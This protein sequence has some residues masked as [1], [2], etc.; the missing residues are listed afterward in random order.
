MPCLH[1]P[2]PL[3]VSCSY[4]KQCFKSKE[5]AYQ[6]LHL[7]T[8]SLDTDLLLCARVGDAK[9]DKARVLTPV[10]FSIWGIELLLIDDE[11]F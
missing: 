8:Y 11:L 2:I 6:V 1:Y 4:N 9:M 10:L 3:T 5:S 7:F